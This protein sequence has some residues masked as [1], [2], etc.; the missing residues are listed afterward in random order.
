MLCHCT[1]ARSKL[2]RVCSFA[3]G[4][5]S[6]KLTIQKHMEIIVHMLSHCFVHML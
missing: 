5:Q 6:A 4:F 3:G 2:L 1:R